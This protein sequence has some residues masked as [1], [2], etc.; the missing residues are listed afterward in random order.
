MT[1]FI[2][3]F[4]GTRFTPLNPS[5]DSIWIEDI[6]HA[7]S[8]LCRF[9][10]HTRVFYSVGEHSW[11]VSRLLEK[12]GEDADVQ[13]WGLMHDAWEAYAGDWATP[14]KQSEIGEGYRL[15]ESK[16]MRIIC[17]RFQMHE[18][19]PEIVKLADAVMLATEARDLMPNKPEHWGNLVVRPDEDRIVPWPIPPMANFMFTER[20]KELDVQR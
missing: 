8:H 12:W 10:G 4:T 9:N 6:S 19:M 14:L 7:L 13:F 20:F 15:A 11:R 16:G 3:T 2:E 1:P 5:V 18:T 17:Q